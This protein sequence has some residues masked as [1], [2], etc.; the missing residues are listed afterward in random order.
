MGDSKPSTRPEP[1]G[2]P[3]STSPRATAREWT[4]LAVIALPCAVYAMDMTVLNLALPSISA[5]LRPSAAQLLWIVDIYGFFV[6]GLLITMGTLGDRIGRRRL[7][8]AGAAA[9]GVASLFAAF[10]TS[11]LELIG[12]R[13]LLGVAGATVAPS[14]MS[15]I[16][17]MFHD[18]HERQFA[19]G[20]WI[21]SYSAGAAVGPLV[22]GVLLQWFWWGSVF[23]VAVP[24]MAL[25]LVLGPALLPEYRDPSAGRVDPPSVV[26]SLGAVLAVVYALK[27]FAEYGLSWSSLG[28]GLTGIALGIAFVHRQGRLTYPGPRDVPHAWA[29]VPDLAQAFVEVAARDRWVPVGERLPEPNTSVLVATKGNGRSWVTIAEG[30]ENVSGK[31]G[32]WRHAYEGW[33]MDNVTHWRPLPEPP[34]GAV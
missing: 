5:S 12:W 16:R 31:F 13:A 30:S 28:I 18:A 24:V 21:A 29:Y 15:L 19:I 26:W 25:L 1:G 34:G 3:G 27:R 33:I 2:G 17:N 22:G 4:G 9:F 7:L 11:A 32:A 23:L 20:V 8:L 10:A 6:A 14:T